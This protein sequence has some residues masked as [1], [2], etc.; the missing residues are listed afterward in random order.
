[1]IIDLVLSLYL[2]LFFP[3]LLFRKKKVGLYRLFSL[4][5]DPQGKEVVWLHAVSLGE[6]KAL[7][8]LFLKLKSIYSDAF[9]L[10]TTTT[11][12]GQDEARRSFQNADSIAYLPF[13]LSFLVK[14][15]VRKLRPF[16]LVLVESDIWPNLL[17]AVK[18]SG[19]KTALVS[20]KISEKS[21]R[22]FGYFPKLAKHLFSKIDL[23]CVQTEE[24]QRRFSPFHPHPQITG[25][26]KFSAQ[27]EPI[28]KAFWQEKIHPLQR[29]VTCASTHKGEE[30][31]FLQLLAID[32]LFLFLVPRHPERFNEVAALL[33]SKEIPFFKWSALELRRGDERVLL[34]DAM[35]KLPIC[36]QLSELAIVGGS[37]VPNIGGHN[38]LEPILYHTPVFFGPHMFNQ[39]ELTS[40]VLSHQAGEQITPSN[41]VSKVTHFFHN[42]DP[43]LKEKAILLASS[44]HHVLDQTIDALVGK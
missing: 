9:F 27:R 26:L 40:Y 19:G 36:Y 35:G 17:N 11:K 37:F 38:V 28:D 32:S 14:A 44:T 13:D 2:L 39:N 25:N 43:S 8:P 5:P 10:I 22:R 3:Y 16:L 42:P 12:T 15:W 7:L 34:V 33:E 41:L 29:S 30:E 21:A 18:Q 31:L 4:P 24:Y 6:V 20:G 23:L 1:M